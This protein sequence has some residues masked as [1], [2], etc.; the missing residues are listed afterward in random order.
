MERGALEARLLARQTDVEVAAACG[1][2]PTAVVAYEALFFEVRDRIPCTAYIQQQ[3]IGAT[4]QELLHERDAEIMLKRLGYLH[5]PD[6]LG[7]MVRYYSTAWSV[8]DALASG[9][10]SRACW[11]WS[12]AS[13]SWS[14]E[15]RASPKPTCADAQRGSRRKA[16]W[17]QLCRN[18]TSGQVTQRESCIRHR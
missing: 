11:Y 9:A 8:P 18:R 13:S 14:L 4:H 17:Y 2:M 1:V 16:C 7:D 10:T 5:G 3:A 6:L 15:R 12:M